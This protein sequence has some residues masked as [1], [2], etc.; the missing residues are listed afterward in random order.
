MTRWSGSNRSETTSPCR[1]QTHPVHSLQPQTSSSQKVGFHA[2]SSSYPPVM[3]GP[4]ANLADFASLFLTHS[5][6]QGHLPIGLHAWRVM[7]RCNP[8]ATKRGQQLRSERQ[9]PAHGLLPGYPTAFCSCVSHAHGSLVF[10]WRPRNRSACAGD[11][12][13]RYKICP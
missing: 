10:L 6:S 3:S 8:C 13:S 12:T 5:P 11:H 1:P 7:I 2:R 4:V 9:E